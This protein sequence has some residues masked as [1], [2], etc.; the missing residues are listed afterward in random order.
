MYE[1]NSLNSSTL[2]CEQK[3]SEDSELPVKEL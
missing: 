3:F 2:F 1:K